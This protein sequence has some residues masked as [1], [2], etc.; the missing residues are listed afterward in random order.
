M[1][2]ARRCRGWC[3]NVGYACW[4]EPLAVS[5]AA[6]SF[7]LV[8]SLVF[9]A[10]LF[11]D[12]RATLSNPLAIACFVLIAAGLFKVVYW[13]CSIRR[14]S[15][16]EAKGPLFVLWVG[17]SFG[18]AYYGLSIV[19]S[20]FWIEGRDYFLEA[21]AL[22]AT[23]AF[24]VVPAVVALAQL[25]MLLEVRSLLH[26]ASETPQGGPGAPASGQSSAEDEQ[27][28][29]LMRQMVK[30]SFQAVEQAN[31]GACVI[32]LV[33]F[34]DEEE[35]SML[36]CRHIFHT[37]CIVSWLQERPMCPMR[38]DI[39]EG[40]SFSP[41]HSPGLGEL[42]PDDEST[43]PGAEAAEAPQGEAVA[44]PPAAGPAAPGLGQLPAAEGQDSVSS[45]DPDPPCN[46]G[47]GDLRLEPVT[48]MPAQL[49]G[50]MEEGCCMVDVFW[51]HP[52]GQQSVAEVVDAA[53]EDAQVPRVAPARAPTAL[54]ESGL[55]GL[56]AGMAADARGWDGDSSRESHEGPPR[57]L[58]WEGSGSESAGREAAGTRVAPAGG[59]AGC[60]G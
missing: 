1:D 26:G 54:R 21:N 30:G 17:S 56:A 14:R 44:E 25:S 20:F 6:E 31:Q 29:E 9:Q 41:E 48:Q 2:R 34:E 16:A 45:Q 38:C 18:V 10:V 23:L 53:A 33:D 8:F 58:G 40:A 47:M 57:C 37:D 36:P 5:L 11:F 7:M 19:A 51:Q 12:Y 35:V 42:D 24:F 59:A 27:R 22:K 4:V 52:D 3:F 55:G 32:C 43:V 39:A 15:P 60:V 50:S 13:W 46:E 28:Q 49:S